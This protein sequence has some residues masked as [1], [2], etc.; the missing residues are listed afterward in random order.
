MAMVRIVA[1]VDA[2]LPLF[3]V[4][5]TKKAYR[6]KSKVLLALV[7]KVAPCGTAQAEHTRDV[8][9]QRQ[10]ARVAGSPARE[11][12]GG[13][14]LVEL[15]ALAHETTGAGATV[16]TEGAHEAGNHRPDGLVRAIGVLGGRVVEGVLVDQ[17][18]G[19]ALAVLGAVEAALVWGAIRG[20]KLVGEC[21][22]PGL[23]AQPL[24]V[25]VSCGGE[26]GGCEARRAQRVKDGG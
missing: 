8:V 3:P 13:R 15:V 5:A 24:G 18:G 2:N 4:A 16:T 10:L 14:Q 25:A 7:V 17:T 9:A 26:R 12:V 6:N 23:E 22:K 21:R 11:G 19:S 20:A 1:R